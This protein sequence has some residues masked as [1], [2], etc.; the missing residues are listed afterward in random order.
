MGYIPLLGK[1]LVDLDICIDHHVAMV[2]KNHEGEP[3][4][5][6]LEF[7]ARFRTGRLISLESGLP[8]PEIR[9]LGDAYDHEALAVA[10][11]CAEFGVP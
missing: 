7:L 11:F 9:E 3:A 2:S 6:E 10:E 1:N 8:A 5:E 4:P